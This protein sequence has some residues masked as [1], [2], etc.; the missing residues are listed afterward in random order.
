M[1][2]NRKTNINSVFANRYYNHYSFSIWN[3][4]NKLLTA[5]FNFLNASNLK[6]ALC[7]AKSFYKSDIQINQLKSK[8][9]E[10]DVEISSH[11]IGKNSII[12]NVNIDYKRRSINQGKKLR[13]SDSFSIINTIFQNKK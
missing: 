5:L 10:I 1:I 3:I 12:K 2:L 11:L 4:G 6:D 13:L 7:C 8:K 9:F